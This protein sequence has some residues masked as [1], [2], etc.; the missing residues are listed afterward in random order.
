MGREQEGVSRM[1]ENMARGNEVR[2]KFVVDLKDK[3]FVPEPIGGHDPD[4][5]LIVTPEDAELYSTISEHSAMIL[6]S[7]EIVEQMTKEGGEKGF[8][9]RAG[10]T[11]TSLTY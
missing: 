5:K 1:I 2:R 7:G 8:F 4:N 3:K 9:L 6:V 10:T 11:A